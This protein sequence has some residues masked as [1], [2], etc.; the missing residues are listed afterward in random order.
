VAAAEDTIK[1]SERLLWFVI[2][3]SLVIGWVAGLFVHHSSI[4][5]VLKK[6]LPEAVRFD[7]GQDEIYTGY[8]DIQGESDEVGYVAIRSAHG[9]AGPV[10]VAVGLDKNGTIFNALIVRQ[11]ESAAFFRLVVDSGYPAK[12]KGKDCTDQFAIG[13][14]VDAVTGATVSLEAVSKAARMACSDIAVQRLGL[15]PIAKKK[16]EIQFGL[17]EIILIL[18]IV[19]G[20]GASGNKLPAKKYVK[21]GV[22]AGSIVFI[23]FVYKWPASLININSLLVGYWPGWRNHIYWYLL[24]AAILLPVILNGKT[25][26]CSSICPFGA[27][28]EIL[29]NIGGTRRQIPGNCLRILKILQRSLAW[30]AVMCALVFRNPALVSYDVSATF[31]TIIGQHWQFV[32]LALVLILSLFI[33]RPWC[34]CLCPLRAVFDFIR[35]LRRSLQF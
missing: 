33:V 30:V 29:V 34:N 18:L 10:T 12:F 25:L 24:A 15:E 23:G 28:Q 35:L 5:D 8:N 13:D 11:T 22:L 1:K 2:L 21:W 3:A 26:Y 6:T 27:T 9:Y 7:S 14:D 16:P 20:F 32:L 17:P 31:F 19:A 4:A